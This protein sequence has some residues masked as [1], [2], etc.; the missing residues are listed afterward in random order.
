MSNETL[1]K[2]IRGL[3][4]NQP[5]FDQLQAMENRVWQSINR[6]RADMPRNIVEGWLTSLFTPRIPPGLV[7][8]C[9]GCRDFCRHFECL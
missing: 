2:L 3:S 6:R 8:F 4:E 1:N 7:I 5:R 9:L